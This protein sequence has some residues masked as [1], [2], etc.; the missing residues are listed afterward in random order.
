M[1]LNLTEANF[2]AETSSGVVLV[3]FWATWCGPCQMMS[4]VI[5]DIA[6]EC[7]DVVKVCKVDVDQAQNLA[8]RF[9]VM[10]IPMIFI[11]KDGNEVAQ[12]LG[13]TPKEKI[14]AAIRSA[15]GIA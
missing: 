8:I 11:L 6:N 9:G 10:S 4:P 12:F 13:V 1:A 14:I 2:D 15:Q 5:D 7:G 3:D